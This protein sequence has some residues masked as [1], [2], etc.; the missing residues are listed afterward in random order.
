M[1]IR[2]SIKKFDAGE[3][4]SYE[5]IIKESGLSETAVESIVNEL[6]NSGVCFEPKPG[7][8]KLL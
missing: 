6:L 2:D 8:I 4:C 3:G 5:K 1:C 7:M